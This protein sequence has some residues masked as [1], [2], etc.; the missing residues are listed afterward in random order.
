[1]GDPAGVGPELTLRAWTVCRKH[2]EDDFF[3]IA[4]ADQLSAQAQHLGLD[5]PI[6][7]IDTP[8]DCAT[9][10]QNALP[11]LDLALSEAV[12]PGHSNTAHAPQILT[13]IETAVR[14]ALARRASGVVTNPIHK[15]S[16]KDSGFHFPGH[17]EYLAHLC[18]HQGVEPIP[19]MM[20]AI[21]RLR[22]V[23]VTI[24][25]ALKDVAARLDV[26]AIVAASRIT[27]EALTRDFGIKAPRL[28]VAALNPHGGEAGHFG[29]EE[30]DIIMPA[31]AKLKSC[32]LNVT[33]PLPADTLFAEHT[34]SKFDAII[35]MYHDQALIPLK[36]LDFDNGVNI[37]LG[38][39]IVRTSP[40]HG[41][42]FDI[43]GQGIAKP[44]SLIAAIKTAR[45]IARNRMCQE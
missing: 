11:V 9:T 30:R 40:D 38:L 10:F 44:N 45:D 43:A 39:P 17:T 13:S 20:L 34:R 16:L 31:I 27:A 18:S 3:A 22:V 29:L 19:V 26:N 28:A 8:E 5:V 36:A 25:L 33:G 12:T 4:S 1:M 2:R 14:L 21:P 24:H 41:T 42:A 15:S 23:P 7:P 35:A 37:T 6:T 32:A